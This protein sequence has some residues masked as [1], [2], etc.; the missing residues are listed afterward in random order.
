MGVM[1]TEPL[2]SHEFR[3]SAFE[4]SNLQD[5]EGDDGGEEDRKDQER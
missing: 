3:L 1:A 5:K 2:Q 4:L